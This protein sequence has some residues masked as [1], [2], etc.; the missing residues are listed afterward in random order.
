MWKKSIKYL[1]VQLDH[2]LSF[3]QHLLVTNAKLIQCGAKLDLLMPN[4]GGPRE[5]KRRLVASV[6]HTKLLYAAPVWAS[7]LSNH[8]IQ[9][10]Q[11]SA[12]RGAALRIVSAYRTVLT[13]AVLILASVLPIDLLAKERQETV[14]LRKELTCF[15]NQQI[16]VRAKDDIRKERRYEHTDYPQSLP[17]GCT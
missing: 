7:A 4:I 3:G 10:K 17:P 14:Q 12:Q 16:N 15:T 8:V 13:S 9:K 2:R 6:V 11:F 5:A 1:R